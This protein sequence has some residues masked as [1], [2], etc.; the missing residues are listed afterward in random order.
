MTLKTIER[1]MLLMVAVMLTACQSSD[2]EVKASDGDDCF[3]DISVCAPDRSFITRGDVGNIAS[4]EAERKVHSLQIWVFKSKDGSPICYREYHEVTDFSSLNASPY[5]QTFKMKVDKAFAETRDNVDIYVVANAESCGLSYDGETLRTTLD[6]AKIGT[7]Y[8]GTTTLVSSVPETGL[9]MSAVLKNQSVT[10]S[11]PAL[12]IGSQSQPAVLQLT[13][14]V[15]KLRFV[16][17]RIKELDSSTKKLVSINSIQLDGSLIPEETYL[18][19]GTYSYSRYV[20]GVISYVDET[21]KLESKDIPQVV[22][23]LE[24]A[25][26]TQSAQEYE[27]LIDKAIS[28]EQKAYNEDENLKEL[29]RTYLRESDR[30]LTGSISY[31]YND[32]GTEKTEPIS[33]SMAGAG[34]FLRNH[35]WIVYIYYMDSKIHILTVTHIGMK[36]W[37]SD[38][39][40]ENTTFYNW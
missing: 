16:L 34:D 36:S 13:H 29:G 11:F 3:L 15:S 26:E 21:H 17:C 31:T 18:M 7:D 28:G 2:E 24:Y 23:P 35:S 22:D 40:D 6:E 38:D 27:N 9:P 20:S 37:T 25:Y 10:G 19:P 1:W 32:N 30:Q 39:N 33:F 4:S 8:F 14:A 12:R 5:Q